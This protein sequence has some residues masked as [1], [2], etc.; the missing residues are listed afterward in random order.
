MHYQILVLGVQNQVQSTGH[1]PNS[2]YTTVQLYRTLERGKPGG[3]CTKVHYQILVLGVQNQ[4]QSTG[5]PP[6]SIYTTVQ[7]SRTLERGKPGRG[8][9]RCTIKFWC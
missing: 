8:A 5:H 1:P 3:G 9:Q 7:L 6:N 2:I 4:V